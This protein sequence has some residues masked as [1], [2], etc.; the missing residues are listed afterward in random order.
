[1]ISNIYCPILFVKALKSF[2]F[3]CKINI[4]SIKK[5]QIISKSAAVEN[6]RIILPLASRHTN[7]AS[8]SFNNASSP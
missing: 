2:L 4:F 1:M 5:N 6:P 7:P 3:I 8:P